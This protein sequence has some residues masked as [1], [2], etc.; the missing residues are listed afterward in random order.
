MIAPV[1][2]LALIPDELSATEAAHL[3][4]AGIIRIMLSV[5]VVLV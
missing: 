4:C 3:M 5:I 2:A 1:E